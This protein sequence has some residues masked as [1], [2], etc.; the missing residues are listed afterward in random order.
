MQSIFHYTESGDYAKRPRTVMTEMP[1]HHRKHIQTG[2][3][4]IVISLKLHVFGRKPSQ[5]VL[6]LPLHTETHMQYRDFKPRR[7]RATVHPTSSPCCPSHSQ[8]TMRDT[9]SYS[10]S[11]QHPIA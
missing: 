3:K 2:I 5:H 7:Y 1:V 10:L 9:H 4:E 6:E 8:A 11:L